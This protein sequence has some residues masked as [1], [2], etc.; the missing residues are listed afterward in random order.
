MIPQ[1][2]NQ[3][4]HHWS[5]S[6]FAYPDYF[7]INELETQ[8]AFLLL[9]ENTHAAWAFCL[10]KVTFIVIYRPRKSLFIYSVYISHLIL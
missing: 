4:S 6:K 5:D 2:V 7:F 9:T 10:R 3:G 8:L 1:A